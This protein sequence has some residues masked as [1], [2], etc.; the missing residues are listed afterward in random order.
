MK[1][2]LLCAINS[3]VVLAMRDLF[4]VVF[5]LKKKEIELARQHI[6]S[7]AIHDHQPVP[8]NIKNNSM[9]LSH[10]LMYSKTNNTENLL[11]SKYATAKEV[12]IDSN[13]FFFQ[14]FFLLTTTELN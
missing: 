3:Q 1:L 2:V 5:E 6:Q 7:K 9:D 11:S 10:L 4:Q 12:G 14:F 13:N 8:L